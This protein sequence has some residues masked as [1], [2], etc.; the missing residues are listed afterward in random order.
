[1]P[2]HTARSHP[3][4]MAATGLAVAASRAQE[5][6]RPDRLFDD[7]LSQCFVDAVPGGVATADDEAPFARGYFAL[8]T[9]W[10]DDSVRRAVAAGV[11]QVV[12]L[13][14]GLDTRAYRL[15]MSPDVR[16]FE[17]DLPETMEF[18]NHVLAG[19]AVRPTARRSGIGADLR[20]D[21]ARALGDAGF[22]AALDTHWVLE[23]ILPYLTTD[24]VERLMA[25]VSQL[26]ASRSSLALEYINRAT[27]ELP[28]LK[29]MLDELADDGAAWRSSVDDPAA[30]LAQLGWTCSLTD[31]ASL[32]H[33]LGREVPMGMNHDI[34]GDARCWLA[35][36]A[37]DESSRR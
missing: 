3:D 19:Q 33:S 12:I 11:R 23:G 20:L 9:R 26:S 21:W 17:L 34:V 5:S 4:G 14:S 6:R 35:E 37:R 28:P 24:A 1:M 36:A 7:D 25:Q 29:A 22:D 27:L 2:D 15:A 16:V 32:A 30:W 8:R 31:V 13:A 18:K 10:F